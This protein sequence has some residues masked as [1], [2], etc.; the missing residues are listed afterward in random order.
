MQVSD[1][2][3]E[4][5]FFI[6]TVRLSLERI[7]AHCV[8]CVTFCLYF[9]KLEST[10]A[11]SRRLQVEQQQ[12]VFEAK[13]VNAL[14]GFL[15]QVEPVDPPHLCCTSYLSV[16]RAEVIVHVMHQTGFVCAGSGAVAPHCTAPPRSIIPPASVVLHPTEN[17]TWEILWRCAFFPT[18]LFVASSVT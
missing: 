4:V 15:T 10:S 16:S 13:K 12:I 7:P 14:F 5:Q 1:E 2:G 11:S 3:Q 9:Q 17:V 6:L 18:M 8:L